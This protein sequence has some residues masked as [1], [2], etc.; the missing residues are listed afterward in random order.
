MRS[1]AIPQI[2]KATTIP[3]PIKGLNA[4]D[5]IVSMPDGFALVLRNLYAQPYGCQVRR[6]S[7]VH[8]ELSG[9][10]ETIASHN[11]SDPKLY[12]FADEGSLSVIYDVTVPNANPPIID[13]TLTNARWQYINFPNA[14]GVNLVA[15]NGADNMIWIQANGNYVRISSGD[16]SIN[17]IAGVDPKALV[18]VVAHQ[19]RLWFVEKDSTKGWYLPPDQ[20]YGVA[21]FFDFGPL[22]SRG[23]RVV[24]IVTWTL[25]DG[26]GA[27]DHLAIITS[28][29]QV[30]VYKG[31]DPEGADTWGLAG[32]YHAGTPVGN[33]PAVRY[34]G[35]VM[36]LTTGGL[37]LLSTLLV[38]TKLNPNE[39][40]PSK[41][42]QQIISRSAS[43]TRDRFGWQPFI[44][45]P[46]NMILVNIPVNDENATQLVMNDIT[47]AWSQFIGWIAWCW[48][49]HKQL[50]FFGTEGAV[51]RAWE[52]YTDGAVVS[53]TGVVTAGEDIRSEAQ[54]SFSYFGTL[55]VQKHYKM[56]R[57]TI[58]SQGYFN[59][60]LSCNTDFVFDNP[61]SPVPFSLSKFGKW[62][63]GLW[64]QA[65]WAGGLTTY[66]RWAA[67]EGIGTAAALRML[68]T[69]NSETYWPTTD[70]LYEVGGV[71]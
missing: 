46:E 2:S 24:Q 42:V 31:T 52:Q 22:M 29:G 67:V 9:R 53:D 27:D 60:A 59:I 11:V 23:G 40:A 32:V 15:V 20:I 30:I 33:R 13:A 39:I 5:S 12:A 57:P 61:V 38:S 47:K 17:T 10:V 28:E 37:V 55:G 3:A 54:T 34:G 14:A 18:H 4:Y 50:L 6:G 66:K 49:T 25:D 26:E 21:K 71:M 56:V 43:L 65:V 36:I 8:C 64:D 70:W 51:Y 44:F 48:E 62:D 35:D 16:G 41:Y 58:M 45:L 7:V 1:Q 68:L 63:E 19:K 69:T